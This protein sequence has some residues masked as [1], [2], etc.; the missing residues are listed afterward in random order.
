VKRSRIRGNVLMLSG[1]SGTYG[2]DTGVFYIGSGLALV[3]AL[4]TFFFIPNIKQDAMHDEDVLVSYIT[5]IPSRL[6]S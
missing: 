4:I 2:G 5:W 1:G 6:V 3:S